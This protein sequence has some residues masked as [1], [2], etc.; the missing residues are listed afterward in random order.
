MTLD[1]SLTSKI[2]ESYSAI[3][4]RCAVLALVVLIGLAFG[5]AYHVYY[6]P[7]IFHSDGAAIQVLAQAMVDEMS[8]LP[9]DFFYGN[10]LILF[11]ANLFIALALKLGLTGYNAY[12]VGSAINF[13]VFFLITFL[14]LEKI[15]GNWVKTLFLSVL[16]FLP[17]NYT[18]ADYVLG[19]QSH[20]ANV[21][22]VLMI[23]VYSYRA[24]WYKEWRGLVIASL[25]AF[26]MV[27]E[28]PMRV[29][30]VLF[31]L[32][33]VIV[34][35]GKAKS[36]LKLSLALVIAFAFGYIGNRYLVMTHIVAVDLSNLAFS[37][38]DRF[39]M[40]MCTILKDF[41]DNYIGFNQ[42]IGM[43]TSPRI[44]LV[45]YGLKTLVLVSFIGMFWWL[46]HRLGKRGV[47]SWLEN[48]G[49]TQCELKA[50][51]FIG[52][53]GVTG[54]LTGFWITSA[55]EYT[56]DQLLRH[57]VGMLQLC[58][59]ALFAYSL[60]ALAY[61]IP[62]RLVVYGVLFVIALLLST[63][64]TS[65]LFAPYRVQLHNKIGSNM[66]WPLNNKIQ[67]LMS[68]HGIN[69]I[70]GG[71]YWST[72]RLEVLIP[73]VKATVLGV[74]DGSVHYFK[75]LTRPSMRCFSGDVFYL[76]EPSKVDEEYIAGK[77][78]ERGGKIL[79][80]IG[81]T[82]IYLGAPVWDRSGCT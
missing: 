80:H 16:F 22:F 38:L 72:L 69:R 67:K 45:L 51:E 13:S 75:W 66:K 48:G 3:I 63:P 81:D 60:T 65:F 14:T 20:L 42:F 6:Y 29:L 26:L 64:V 54:V 19:Q 41:V 53:L 77:I 23:A 44:H 74:G 7:A 68:A 43:K 36:A 79:E 78:L 56:D 35:T 1:T 5:M 10:Q 33:L 71:N 17:F 76:I 59:L 30:F 12:A 18:E 40:R 52:L 61:L 21:V 39:L 47:K 46:A 31:P 32:A 62:Q 49:T 57:S 4:S 11:R 82:D 34:V 24:C 2:T 55:V 50:L 70:Y 15:F 58:K 25:V 73:P 28:A 8:L 37:T 9:H 27:W